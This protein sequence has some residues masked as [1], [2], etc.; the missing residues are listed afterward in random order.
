MSASRSP[1]RVDFKSAL[2]VSATPS[3]LSTQRPRMCKQL[4][5]PGASMPC[6]SRKF[7][8]VGMACASTR[9]YEAAGVT[10]DSLVR[11]KIALMTWTPASDELTMS[12]RLCTP[13][14]ST[15]SSAAPTWCCASSEMA[16][17]AL[18]TPRDFGNALLMNCSMP[19]TAPASKM[20]FADASGSKSSMRANICTA[21]I[22]PLSEPVVS[23]STAY[24]GIP[25]WLKTKCATVLGAGCRAIVR[26][27]A[28]HEL[29][30]W[31]CSRLVAEEPTPTDGDMAWMSAVITPW[32]SKTRS[33]ATA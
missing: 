17:A 10:T 12:S 32:W 13:P 9:A 16:S 22:T 6:V 26:L 25:S 24:P 8:S 21:L 28:E 7:T 3:T 19:A 29:V 27:S 20:A 4:L 1:P 11:P 30:R 2:T 14:A 5:H 33:A 23:I 31:C 15:I 18:P